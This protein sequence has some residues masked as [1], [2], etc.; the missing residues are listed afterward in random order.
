[1]D[2][3]SSDRLTLA[4]RFL[5][6]SNVAQRQYEALRAFFCRGASIRAGGYP[7]RLHTWILQ[8]PYASVPQPHRREFFLV[9]S[10]EGRPPSKE[11][12]LREQVIALRKQ[13]LLVHDISR[14]LT[15]EGESLSPAAIAVILKQ[16]ALPSYPD[17]LTTS[18]LICHVPW[19]PRRLM[20]VNS[21][22]RLAAFAP[23]SAGCFC[24]CPTWSRLIRTAYSRAAASRDQR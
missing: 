22:Y 13:N 1:M 17:D 23:N 24:S 10:P 7:I 18:D 2:D 20:S 4:R 3:N 6:P 15:A 14:S 8:G 21:T 19:Q 12:R 9:P 5:K 16:R 11:T